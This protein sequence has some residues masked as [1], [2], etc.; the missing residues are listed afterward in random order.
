MTT[1]PSR[2]TRRMR[3]LA[4][5]ARLKGE[6]LAEEEAFLVVIKG[7]IQQDLTCRLTL[8]ERIALSAELAHV[9]DHYSS[10]VGLA[11]CSFVKKLTAPWHIYELPTTGTLEDTLLMKIQGM[12]AQS[13][14]IK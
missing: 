3:A 9:E 12:D 6:A 8:A 13:G 2:D 14:R 1:C 11:A 5:M 4:A 7:L 10:T